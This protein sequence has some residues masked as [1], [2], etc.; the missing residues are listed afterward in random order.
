MVIID[1]MA[2]REDGGL[3]LSLE[4][5]NMQ[6]V[7]NQPN[8]EKITVLVPTL[9]VHT[10]GSFGEF[11]TF[12]DT[13]EETIEKFRDLVVQCNTGGMA[14]N[15][16]ELDANIATLKDRYIPKPQPGTNAAGEAPDA[17]NKPEISKSDAMED[18]IANIAAQNKRAAMRALT[19]DEMAAPS[20]AGS[21][22]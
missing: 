2:F 3:L 1:N 22:D 4:V 14:I 8:G 13:P 20:E 21:D 11:D 9:V 5:K 7:A 10:R 15:F 12:A 6:R 18:A 17:E 19:P 16:K